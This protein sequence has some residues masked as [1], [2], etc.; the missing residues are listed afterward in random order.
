LTNFYTKLHIKQALWNFNYLRH[1]TND[2]RQKRM[3]EPIRPE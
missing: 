3:F 1:K 2:N